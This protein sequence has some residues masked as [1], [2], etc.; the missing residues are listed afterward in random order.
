MAADGG[1]PKTIHYCQYGSR[2]LSE[3][4][5]SCFSSWERVLPDYELRVWNE[6]SGLADSPYAQAA[7]K[8][9]KYA[10]VADYIR[11]AA[12]Y[13]HGGVYLD[14]DVEVLR[15][16]DPLLGQQMFLG[17]EAPGLVGTAI[18]GARPSAAAPLRS[19]P[20]SE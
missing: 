12:L 8:A 16:F 10:F 18:I 11:C 2:G 5:E 14:T 19:R 9:R 3:V 20:M 4:G 15:P 6:G 1:I 7:L 13:T 17:Y